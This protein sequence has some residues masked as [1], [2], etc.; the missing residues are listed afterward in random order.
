MDGAQITNKKNIQN[1]LKISIII[2]SYNVCSYLRQCLQSIYQSNEFGA[3]EIIVVDNYSYDESCQ[4]VLN[5]FSQITLIKNKE[6]LGF[7]KAVNIG[8]DKAAGEFICI[9]NPDTLISDNTFKTLLEH[10]SQN[11][12]TGCIGPKILNPNG[13]LQL[14]CKRSFPSPLT[15]FFKFIGL[16]RL[17]PTSSLF[18]RYNLTYLNE[19]EIHTVDALSGSFML[20]PQNIVDEVGKLDESFFMY[21]EDLDF[22]YRIQNAGYNIVY[23]PQTSIIHYKGESVKSAPYDMI[24]I[25]YSALYKF[26]HKYSNQFPS[27]K[28]LRSVVSLGIT[29][30]KTLAYFK[31][32][33]T[34]I[35][36]W[37]LDTAS[38]LSCFIIAMF[39]WYPYYHGEVVTISSIISHWPLILNIICCWAVSSYW[40][41][42]YK[43]NFLSYGRSLVV[44]MLA[45]LMSATSTYFIAIIAY[46]RAVLAITF[47]L[48]AGVSAS[49][50]I[51]VYLLYRYQKIKL[52]VRA[53]LFSRRA[54]ILGT[55][56]ESMRIGDLLHHTPETHFILMGY[57][58][59]ENY[60]GTKNFLGRIEH[61]NGLVKNHNINEIIIPE[62]Y[63]NIRELIYLLGNLSDTNV[64]CKLVPKG[65]KMLIG[66]GMVENL[67][68]V[69]LMDIELPL[70]EKIH[71]FTKRIFDILLSSF[72]II[73][74]LPIQ[75]YFLLFK[76]Y[77]KERIWSTDGNEVELIRYRSKNQI[78]QDLPLLFMILNGSL[79]FVGSQIVDTSNHDPQ[80]ILKPGLTGL[81]HL[82]AVHIQSNSIREFENYYA[83]HY[84]LIFDIEII[85]KSILKI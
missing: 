79:S 15:A 58:D 13:T 65:Q 85:L 80:L 66:K 11:P 69:T 84:S 43:K 40:L 42:L 34:R 60:S 82:K 64:H 29:F 67:S 37:V 25:F 74:T 16:S 36:A 46:S 55:G 41:H 38:I 52:S 81:P 12:K 50:R 5:E 33:S 28:F 83:M 78:I 62:K 22:C 61:I 20:F 76:K 7:A 57:I 30:R 17:F 24:E 59:E 75:L 14:A 2:V 51:G 26:Y 4:M 32:Y 27:W 31:V 77:K 47:L 45:F 71:Q 44:A 8:I 48:A 39:F 1:T 6:N 54:A 3:F 70:F 35:T 68:G 19:N 18:G 23:N 53:P 56:K 63:V 10:I 21:G 73:S 9:L 49:W 72:L